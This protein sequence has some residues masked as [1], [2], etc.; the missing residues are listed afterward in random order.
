MAET[1][2]YDRVRRFINSGDLL[3]WRRPGAIS[4]VGRGEH[5]HTGLAVWREADQCTLSVAEFREFIGARVAN[6]RT[7]VRRDPGIIDVYRPK[8]PDEKHYPIAERA[9]TILYNQAGNKYSYVDIAR[10]ALL[11]LPIA[12][13]V[14]NRLWGFAADLADEKPSAWNA[15]KFCSYA[16]DWAYRRAIFELGYPTVWKPLHELPSR[17]VEPSDLTRSGS[18]ELKYRGLVL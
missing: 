8:W 5:S 18:F 6:L 14:A 15:K 12:S 4:W 1:T 16:V 2:K 9:A 13:Y 3:A 7:A 10:V 11:Q 17:Y